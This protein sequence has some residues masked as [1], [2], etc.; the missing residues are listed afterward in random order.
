MQSM[1]THQSVLKHRQD[2]HLLVYEG[3]QRQM[4]HAPCSTT[5]TCIYLLTPRIA[6]WSAADAKVACTGVR[7]MK[8][9]AYLVRCSRGYVLALRTAP[10]SGALILSRPSP[11]RHPSH[12]LSSCELMSPL[13]ITPPQK[14][15]TVQSVA[16]GIESDKEPSLFRGTNFST[17]ISH[18]V[19]IPFFPRF[20]PVFDA[21]FSLLQELEGIGDVIIGD[22]T[23][24]PCAWEGVCAGLP[25]RVEVYICVSCGVCHGMRA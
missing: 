4:P 2:A 5:G 22:V 19:L 16:R 7:S 24:V 3:A 17:M 18:P 20:F 21:F 1:C 12:T 9:P 23:T 6:S 14:I 15:G 11:L 13:F 25:A 10:R 8:W